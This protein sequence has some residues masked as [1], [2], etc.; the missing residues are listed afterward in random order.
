MRRL[1][2]LARAPAYGRAKTRLAAD[3]GKGLA[4]R[5]ARAMLA[6]CWAAAAAHADDETE[7]QLAV[8]DDATAYP[9]L[10][11]EPET[12]V[13][14]P[15]GDLGARMGRLALDAA[16]QGRDVLLLGTDAPGLPSGITA[17]ALDALRWH[18]LVLGPVSDGG[19]WCLGLAAGAAARLDEGWLDGLDWDADDTRARTETRARELGLTVGE[20]LPAFDVDRGDD[21]RRLKDHVRGQPDVAPASA[22]ALDLEDRERGAPRISVVVASLDEGQRL[23]ECLAALARQPGPYE[24]IVADG[25]S[26]DGGP[27]RAAAAGHT[28]LCGPRGRGPQL[29]AGAEHA[30]GDVILFLH[31]D[32]GL[33]D[34]AFDQVRAAVTGGAEAGAFVT[35]TQRDPELANPLG[36]LLRLA[37]LRSRLTRHPYGDQAIFATREAYDAVGGMRPLPIMEDYDLSVRL[38]ARR[39][40]ARI[41][42]PVRVSGRRM[43]RHPVRTAVLMR[44]IPP[45]YRMGVDPARLARMY[46]GS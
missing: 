17:A 37:D 14:Q 1:V 18:D 45:L 20:A 39:P 44:L 10:Q 35:R 42:T 29:A 30:S 16:R 9:L 22:A 38:A 3:E 15:E 26:R 31:V 25:G 32:T 33:P 27:E 36:P 21:L 41:A 8:C 7:V 2:V 28:V 4:C 19:Y 24:V 40:L 6:D 13:P 46:R 11:P 12:V 43:Q 23:D 5:M 34:G